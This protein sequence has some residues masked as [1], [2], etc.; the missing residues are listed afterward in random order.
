MDIGV[1]SVST[2]VWIASCDQDVAMG[3]TRKVLLEID[4]WV[5]GVVEQQQPL[6]ALSG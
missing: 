4:F 2:A 3:T 5:I 1:W 6:R